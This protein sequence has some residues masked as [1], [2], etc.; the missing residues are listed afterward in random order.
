MSELPEPLTPPDCDCTDL[1]GFMMNVERLMASELVAL[2]SHAAVGAALFLWCRAWKQLPAA[3]LPDDDRVLAAFARLPLKSFQKI[4]S[5]VMRGF[6]KCNDGRLYHAFL[7]A[8]ARR[9]FD[10]KMAFRNKR[11][12]EAKRLKDWRENKNETRTKRVRNAYD[13]DDETRTE[14][15]S[16]GKDRDRDRDGTGQ[17]R[18]GTGKEENTPQPPQAGESAGD[19]IPDL[20]SGFAEFWKLYP[21]AK[22][23][24]VGKRKCLAKW[25]SRKLEGISD[26]IVDGL[27]RWKLSEKWAESDGDF[28]PGPEK[29][30][31]GDYWEA[32]PSPKDP[33]PSDPDGWVDLPED[34]IQARLDS[35]PPDENERGAA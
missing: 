28:I 24:K 7:S 1:D 33:N 20:P 29:F 4:K 8:E 13:D 26:Q 31:N 18:Y 6:V 17:G 27:A 22:G 3:S 14:R 19:E 10:R 5:E 30:L 12:A 16:Y 32:R 23:R 9:A 34:E 2:S 11:D 21:D 25:K 15:V 35:L